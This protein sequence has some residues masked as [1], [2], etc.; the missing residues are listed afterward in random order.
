MEKY[1]IKVQSQNPLG[2]WPVLSAAEMP[3]FSLI[4]KLSFLSGCLKLGAVFYFLPRSLVKFGPGLLLPQIQ[5]H[6]EGPI[7]RFLVIRTTWSGCWCLGIFFLKIHWAV[8]LGFLYFLMCIF[9][10]C[11]FNISCALWYYWPT[12]N[13]GFRKWI[14]SC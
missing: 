14:S 7:W 9:L 4:K 11:A 1:A 13:V 10:Q 6:H 8:H 3:Y 5:K 2:L 12:R